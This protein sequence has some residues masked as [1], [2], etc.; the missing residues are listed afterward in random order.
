VGVRE[1]FHPGTIGVIGVGRMGAA[2]CG[3]L[4]EAGFDLVAG[5][6]D[7]DRATAA[8]TAGARWAGSPVD[9]AASADVLIT[10]LPGTDE[11]VEAMDTLAPALRPGT[12]W[13][14]MTSSAPGASADVAHTLRARRVDCIEAPAGGDP[15]AAR[16]GEL[17]LFVGGAVDAVERCRVVLEALG[18]VEHVGGPGAGYTTKLLVN[19]VWFGQAV[20]VA[21]ALL[22]AARGGIDVEV[23][24]G[25]L[26]RSAADSR[27]AREALGQLLD[28]DYLRTFGLD[29]CCEEL[30]A[31]AALAESRG[32]RF[33]VS[34]AVQRIYREALERYGPIDGELL[35]VALLEEQAGVR[36]RRRD[37]SA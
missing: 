6:R 35:P 13:I 17:Q 37:G 28:G 21:E 20:V 5:D 14:D 23:L 3:R 30:D 7:M 16:A 15:M 34:A 12:C 9:V 2:V 29:R 26:T 25:V 10:V 18:H 4:V 32:V 8:R 22:V 36:L 19:L 24:R 33:T 27:F 11:L 31:I 1:S